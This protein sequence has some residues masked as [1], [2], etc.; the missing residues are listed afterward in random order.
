MAV[1]T[2]DRL[3]VGSDRRALD[4]VVRTVTA[5]LL[6]SGGGLAAV[7][8][9]LAALALTSAEPGRS[10]GVGAVFGLAC[11]GL[12]A[13]AFAATGG[14]RARRDVGTVLVADAAGLWM[15]VPGSD[16][17]HVYLP[18]SAVAPLRETVKGTH[19]V[20]AVSVL[21]HV[22]PDHPGA[23]GLDD[24]RIWKQLRRTGL[25]VGTKGLDVPRGTLRRGLHH[26]FAG[27]GIPV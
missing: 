5:S 23:V 19:S 12:G 9:L 3:E 13:L 14:V 27:A 10:L 18:W 20:F 7:L 11:F 6:V 25:R 8:G 24:P 16:A 2:N 22:R 4:A 1:L 15:A 26:F 17:G 21:P